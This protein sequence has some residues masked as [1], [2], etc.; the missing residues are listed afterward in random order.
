MS[1]SDNGSLTFHAGPMFSGKSSALIL[2]KAELG[3]SSDSAKVIVLKCSPAHEEATLESCT[4]KSRDGTWCEA[5]VIGENV[6]LGELE[7]LASAHVLIDEAQFLSKQQV[8]MLRERRDCAIVCY[9]LRAD[10]H[11][12]PFPGSA[13]LMASADHLVMHKSTCVL[14][15]QTNALH[16]ELRSKV[17]AFQSGNKELD[18]KPTSKAGPGEPFVCENNDETY[19]VLCTRCDVKVRV[20][21]A[22]TK[23]RARED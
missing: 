19:A 20:H 9:G 10:V 7:E 8:E 5:F 12:R 4:L 16:N 17:M 11:K 6:R 2:K 14:C 18:D 23:K 1:D 3:R 13:A 22:P 15:Y 21:F